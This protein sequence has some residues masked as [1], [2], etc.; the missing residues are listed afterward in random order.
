M[1]KMK[2]ARSI[3]VHFPVYE[4]PKNDIGIPG[5]LWILHKVVPLH[6]LCK[7]INLQSVFISVTPI[8][9]TY[10]SAA[11]GAAR[12][13]PAVIL[14]LFELQLINTYVFDI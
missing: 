9:N 3:S 6:V 8:Q 13:K 4:A 14:R 11:P 2:K 12:T 10:C 5:I 1:M 7:Q